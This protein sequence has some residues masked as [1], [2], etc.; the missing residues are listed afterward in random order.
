MPYAVIEDG[1]VVNIIVLNEE[2]AAE[3]PNAVKLPDKPVDI[4]DSYIDGE[5]LNV[6][7][8]LAVQ[9]D[10]ANETIAELDAMVVDLI[11]QNIQLE[12]GV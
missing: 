3:F 8:L 9:L 6:A 11:Y 1:V 4:G 2:N 5:F 7:E 10:T 12:L